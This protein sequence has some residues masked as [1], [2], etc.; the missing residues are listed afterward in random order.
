MGFNIY[1][2]CIKKYFSMKKPDY[3]RLT[4]SL[5]SDVHDVVSGLSVFTGMP[6]SKVITGL[7]EESLPTLQRAL[8]AMEAAKLTKKIDPSVLERMIEDGQRILDGARTKIR[9]SE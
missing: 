1:Q 8:E 3:T 2:H 6:K 9:E 4:I 5:R 7:L